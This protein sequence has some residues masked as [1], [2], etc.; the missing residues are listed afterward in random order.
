MF[1]ASKLLAFLTEPLAWVAALVAAAL[2]LLVPVL[3]LSVPP[4]SVTASAPTVTFCRSRLAPLATL[5]LPV[6]LPQLPPL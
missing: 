1:L 2:L 6:V 4:L 5:V 3:I